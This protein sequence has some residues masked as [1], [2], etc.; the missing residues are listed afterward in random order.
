MHWHMWVV[1]I[2]GIDRSALR[3]FASN[4]H[5]TPMAGASRLP[6]R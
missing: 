3:L 5:I 4:L 6:T 1:R 2:A